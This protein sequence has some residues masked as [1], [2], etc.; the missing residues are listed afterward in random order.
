M[1]HS[2]CVDQNQQVRFEKFQ[3]RKGK[4]LDEESAAKILKEQGGYCLWEQYR[5][6]VNQVRVGPS[7]IADFMG[8]EECVYFQEAQD[9]VCFMINFFGLLPWTVGF[10]SLSY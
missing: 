9:M 4:K 5:Q 8:C 10:S 1:I 3:A 6:G 2:I 7:T